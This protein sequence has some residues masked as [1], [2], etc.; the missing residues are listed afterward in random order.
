MKDIIAQK[1]DY[2]LTSIYVSYLKEN[3]ETL[4]ELKK[5]IVTSEI[6][7]FDPHVLCSN[8]V[9]GFFGFMHHF[10]NIFDTYQFTLRYE[11]VNYELLKSL[12]NDLPY[13]N[14]LSRSYKL[15]TSLSS[16]S[17]SLEELAKKK[18]HRSD[19]IEESQL[20][21]LK[22]RLLLCHC[23]KQSTIRKKHYLRSTS[24]T[25]QVTQVP[26]FEIET[27]D[28]CNNSK[29]I[30]REE[31][32]EIIA[33]S[34]LSEGKYK[35]TSSQILTYAKYARNRQIICRIS[36]L[37]PLANSTPE[38]LQILKLKLVPIKENTIST[39]LEEKIESISMVTNDHIDLK[40]TPRNSTGRALVRIHLYSDLET[41]R[42]E[43]IAIQKSYVKKKKHGM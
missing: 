41:F 15:N 25:L 20:E 3:I 19:K 14:K 38:Y 30:S 33:G 7:F 32:L 27:I 9:E 29:A 39:L 16:K 6:K 24:Q 31:K 1:P 2:F 5:L 17:T 4:K 13:H 26:T 12:K 23:F 37:S 8:R 34:L 35:N 43:P 22:K 21:K 10:S 28:T 11:Y 18:F 42:S 40:L 36:L